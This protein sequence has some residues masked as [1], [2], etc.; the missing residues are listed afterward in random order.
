MRINGEWYLCD[1]EV[2]RPVIRGEVMN[3]S[4]FWEP[5]LF[6]VDTG[7]DR[8]VLSA[9]ILELLGFQPNET[10]DGI[11]GVGGIAK[12]VVINTKIRLSCDD[13]SKAVFQGEYAALTHLEVLDIS[14]LGR[15]MM[16]M[17]SVIVDRHAEV[18]C[19][20]QQRHRYI[21]QKP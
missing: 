3:V 11:G 4:G 12:S 13:E 15:D 10:V 8:T 5:A 16:D 6:L 18:V 9:A 14:V 19:L 2:V 20:L 21:I 1:D 7:A 17:F